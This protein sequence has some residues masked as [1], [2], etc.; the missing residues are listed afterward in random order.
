MAKT[1]PTS[2]NNLKFLKIVVLMNLPF[3]EPNSSSNFA[4]FSDTGR[5]TISTERMYAN[6]SSRR[7]GDFPKNKTKLCF[8]NMVHI[9]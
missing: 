1:W 9:K 4:S 3:P 6:A 2:E 8:Y 7:H 5:S